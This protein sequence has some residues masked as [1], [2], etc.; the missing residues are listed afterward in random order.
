M[1]QLFDFIVLLWGFIEIWTLFLIQKHTEQHALHGFN[2]MLRP[3]SEGKCGEAMVKLGSLVV[4]ITSGRSVVSKEVWMIFYTHVH[5]V[6]GPSV[7]LPQ[8]LY[9]TPRFPS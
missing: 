9:L 3:L 6:S 4:E 2:V 1:Y 8:E 7:G 5:V